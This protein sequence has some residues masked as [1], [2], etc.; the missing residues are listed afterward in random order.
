MN[1]LS[2][3]VGTT[4]CKC[5]LFSEDGDIL[6][7]ITKEYSLK[8]IDGFACADI[9]AIRENVLSM[10]KAVAC[11]H[12][13]D[14]IC[15][16]TFGETFVALDK[17]DNIL[18]DPMLYLMDKRGEEQAKQI[19]AMLG[20]EYVFRTT[21]TVPHTMYS[22]SK[23]LWV[24]ENKPNIY[25]KID[26]VLLICDY[27]GYVLTGKRVIDYSLAAR[28]GVIDIRELRF[29]HEMC[30]K[31]G[32]KEEWFSV[33]YRAGHI[34]GKVVNR[35]LALE[36]CTLVLGAHDQVCTALGAGII[37][38]NRAVDGM[39]TV[40]CITAVYRGP[41]EDVRMGEQGYTCIPYAVDGLYCTYIVNYSSG[42]L[43]NWFKNDILH[44]YK[45]EADNVFSY[46]EK[47]MKNEPTGIY[48]LP[49][50]AGAMIP[51]QDVNAKGAIIGLTASTTDSQIY[52]A[53][54]EGLSMEM[55]F[56]SSI[57]EKYG[58]CVRSAVAT[59]GGANSKKWLQLKADIQGIPYATLRS[60]EGGLCGCAV[61][62]AVAGG[63][64]F[65]D[66]VKIFVKIK[67]KFSPN[68]DRAAL[69][70]PFYGKYKDLYKS[71]KEF[72]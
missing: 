24:K 32:I 13:I 47:G 72:Y 10:I 6:D 30:H 52:Q 49:Y 45:G 14:S 69:Y 60:S 18:F 36:D 40:E 21:G 9:T 55:C 2:I 41:K 4:A 22:V 46:L 5:Q 54:M 68:R 70:A 35:E 50:F 34:V 39:G 29:S 66:A 57:T 27:L 7:Y 67:D 51:Y 62:Q 23:L 28:A 71:V 17:E 64:T 12:K 26:K 1:Y 43:I 15:I 25:Q 33:P 42:L 48:V 31:L 16:S 65:R 59:G 56:E 58:I 44:S 53:I 20:N 37:E 8:Y 61:L 11:K 19:S 38:E 3:D 63:K